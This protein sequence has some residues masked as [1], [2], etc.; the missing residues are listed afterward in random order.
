MS[1]LPAHLN[2]DVQ[3]PW[4]L[5]GSRAPWTW[6]WKRPEGREQPYFPSSC[7]AWGKG[8]HTVSLVKLL[9]LSS[10]Q[11]PLL[12]FEENQ[13]DP[14]PSRWFCGSVLEAGEGSSGVSPAKD[15]CA[16]DTLLP[17]PPPAHHCRAR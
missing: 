11:F 12:Y 8:V 14:G 9:I 2:L 7:L 5:G 16:F 6:E 1:H 17:Y 3:L 15:H 10:P 13:P 4:G